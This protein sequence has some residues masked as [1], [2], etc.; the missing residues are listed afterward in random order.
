L[1]AAAFN[2]IIKADYGQGMTENKTFL[3]QNALFAKDFVC[4]TE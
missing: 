4:Y 2:C 3:S 1:A